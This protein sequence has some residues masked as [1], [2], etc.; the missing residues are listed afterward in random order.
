[1]RSVE[2]FLAL[3][4]VCEFDFELNRHWWPDYGSFWVIVGAILTQNAKWSS[5]EKSLANLRDYGVKELSDIANLDIEVLS[6]LIKPSGFYNTKAKRLSMLCNKIIDKFDNFDEFSSSVSFEW[7]IAQKG[8]GL[9]SV[10]SILCFGCGRDVMV[11]DSYTNRIL[12]ALGFEF[13]SYEEAREWLEGID[14]DEVYKAIGDISDNELF[15]RYHGVIVEFCKSHL[16]GAKFD[17]FALSLFS[18]IAI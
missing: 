17:D 15:C 2:L 8:L 9:E 18:E 11:V 12:S 10:Y 5:V 14:R 7:L 1:M 6:E 3:D 16:K 4:G 13:E